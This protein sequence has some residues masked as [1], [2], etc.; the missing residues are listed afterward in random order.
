MKV[1][2]LVTEYDVKL[3]DDRDETMKAISC[4]VYNDYSVKK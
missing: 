4:D 1:N 2:I 3:L